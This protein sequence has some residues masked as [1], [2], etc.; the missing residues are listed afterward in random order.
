MGNQK[1]VRTSSMMG[2]ARGENIAYKE[3][4]NLLEEGYKV[5]MCNPIG[6]W[7]EYILE[8]EDQ[9]QE[10]VVNVDCEVI[11][12]KVDVDKIHTKLVERINKQTVK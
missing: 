7:L 12:G 6:N 4:E 9:P 10:Y 1:V 5:V 11:P 8:K 3:L 2:I